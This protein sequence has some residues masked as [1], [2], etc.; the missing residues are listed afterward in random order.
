MRLHL[1]IP[2]MAVLLAIVS[3]STP[4]EKTK[5]ITLDDIAA[6]LRLLDENVLKLQAE[7]PTTENGQPRVLPRTIN[8]DGSLFVTPAGDW[9]SGFYPGV[10][11]YMYEL[12]GEAEWKEKAVKYTAFLED[13]QYNGSNHDVGFRMFC[14]Y[15]NALRLT[16]D[17]SY[18]P[19]LVQSARTL[20]ARYNE[21]VGCIRSWDF[22]Q[23]NWQCPVIIDNMMNLEL[24]FWASEPLLPWR[25]TSVRITALCM[26]ST[27]IRSQEEYVKRTPTRAMQM[28]HP[29]PG[30][31][32][33]AYTAIP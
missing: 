26:W 19:V 12:T 21:Q 8:K 13:Q 24:L 3:C 9:T 25:T 11:W 23:E 29:G 5:E 17:E 28:N 6:Q 2:L 7:D 14:S 1:V 16:G 20:I 18:V 30:D 27:M 15:G 22:N 10:L 31:S 32:P 33:G 4:A